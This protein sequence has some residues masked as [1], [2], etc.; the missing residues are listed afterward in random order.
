VIGFHGT[1]RVA[2]LGEVELD[3]G[4]GVTGLEPADF[5]LADSVEFLERQ[6]ASAAVGRIQRSL[7]TGLVRLDPTTYSAFGRQNT[8]L[9]FKAIPP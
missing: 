4:R 5:G 7:L 8:F 9:F 6:G 1:D 2:V 3:G